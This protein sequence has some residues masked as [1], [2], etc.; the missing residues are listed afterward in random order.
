M[1]DPRGARSGGGEESAAPERFVLDL[2]SDLRVIEQ[3]VSFLVTRCREYDFNGSRLLLNFR[4]GVTEALA[5]AILYGNRRDPEK[6]VRIA[7]AL[8]E[9]AV[10]VEVR[11]EGSGFDPRLVP[12]P[13]LP[14]NLERPGGRGIFLLRK[15]MDDVQY[16][17]RGNC[18]RLRLNRE[19]PEARRART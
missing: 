5:N 13:T 7:V 17:E 6:R 1:R 16:D 2:P 18:V 15:L 4:V 12:D 3:T 14:E 19:P 8:N 11:D 10:E 9:D